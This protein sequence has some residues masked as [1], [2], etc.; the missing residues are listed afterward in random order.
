MAQANA[1]I[2]VQTAAF[3]PTFSIGGD[4]GLQSATLANWF[5]WPSRFFSVGP[6]ASQVLFDAGARRATLAN[7]QAQY[8]A[9]V[10]GYR[11]TV[12]T[13][14]QQT[15]DALAA[16]RLLAE[17]IQQQQEAIQAAQ[18]YLDLA[19]TLYKAG[20]DS[21]LDVF[22][23]ETSLLTQQQTGVTLRTQQMTSNVQLI[24]AVGGGWNTTQLPSEHEVAAKR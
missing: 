7:Y 13:A 8:D 20:V 17:Q 5:T 21:F 15:E 11:Q 24:E 18:H 4:A 23:A 14:F 2:G 1:L 9:D 10:A 19:T 6:S 3:Y 12:L 16:Q 22:T